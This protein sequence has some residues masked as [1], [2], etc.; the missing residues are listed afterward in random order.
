MGDIVALSADDDEEEGSLQFALLQALW[1]TSSKAKMVQVSLLWA[2]WTPMVC[3]CD[4]W[5]KS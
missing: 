3:E 5:Q 4:L 2:F 1:Q